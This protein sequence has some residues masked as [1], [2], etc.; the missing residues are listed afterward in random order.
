M[1]II[2]LTAHNINEEHICSAISDKKCKVGDDVANAMIV[3]GRCGDGF[4][5]DK[6]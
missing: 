2:Q 6:D 3:R 5:V 4:R 1:K